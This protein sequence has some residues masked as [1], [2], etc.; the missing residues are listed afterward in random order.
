MLS[1]G[2]DSIDQHDRVVF[3]TI[4]LSVNV[5]NYYSGY[6]NY[7]Y[8]YYRFVI[9]VP[10]LYGDYFVNNLQVVFPKAWS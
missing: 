6:I 1:V 9:E 4:F 10:F 3:G 8:S 7:R 5:S 2:Q